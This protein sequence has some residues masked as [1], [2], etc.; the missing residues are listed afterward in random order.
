MAKLTSNQALIL[1]RL[2][3]GDNLSWSSI[4]EWIRNIL[5]EEE[6]ISI[7]V[8]GSKKTIRAHNPKSLEKFI[9][10]S[11]TNGASLNEWSSHYNSEMTRSKLVKITGDSKSTSIR[12]FS[13]FML[14]CIE[15]IQIFNGNTSILL[16]STP[17]IS[18]Y[19]QNPE[20]FSIP[21]NVIVVGIENAENFCNLKKQAKLFDDMTCIFVSRYPQNA[22]LYRWLE[23][24]PNKYLHFGDFDL[25]GINIY[26]SEFYSR[27]QERASMLV[28]KDIEQ[29]L[30]NG[31]TDLFD[32]QYAKFKSM[33]IKD[34]RLQS[35]YDMIM[36]YHR[37]YEQEG[38]IL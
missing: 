4:P 38:Y 12:T 13:G 34:K 23:R 25:A 10:T 27:L 21:N 37:C 9:R 15:P 1:Q 29:R 8:A 30:M 26:Q 35:L 24:I 7:S 32:K 36:K 17:G 3:S 16:G 18:Y 20:L 22:S 33:T 2:I 6:L 28:P 19:I 11:F 31:N 14:D 5:L